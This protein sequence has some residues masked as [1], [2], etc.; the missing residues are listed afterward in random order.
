MPHESNS[1][2]SD[3]SLARYGLRIIRAMQ[4]SAARGKTAE[5][6]ATT[7]PGTP[8]RVIGWSPIRSCGPATCRACN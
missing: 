4:S 1:A 3:V 5:R 2:A 7:R 8:A 6:V